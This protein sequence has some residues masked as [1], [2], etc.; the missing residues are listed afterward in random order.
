MTP[1]GIESNLTS[2]DQPDE[3][4][5]FKKFRGATFLVHLHLDSAA[6]VQLLVQHNQLSI[7]VLKIQRDRHVANECD[8]HPLTDKAVR[9]QP[10]WLVPYRSESLRLATIALQSLS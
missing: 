4:R 9:S 10:E 6:S 2:L 3:K 1:A 7:R 5:P 8:H